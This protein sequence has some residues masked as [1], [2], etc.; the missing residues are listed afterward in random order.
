MAQPA[1]A[2]LSVKKRLDTIRAFDATGVVARLSPLQNLADPKQRPHHNSS[3]DDLLFR[4]FIYC[5]E[6][7]S[8]DTRKRLVDALRS[9]AGERNR[10]VAF[11]TNA[12]DLGSVNPGGHWVRAL[13]F[14]DIFDLFIYEQNVEA[15]S[16]TVS[17]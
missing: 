13:M 1:W 6:Q 11:C 15:W 3:P 12:S 16:P 9:Y 7:A 10:P 17:R 8:F 4:E 5:Q 2:A 14:A